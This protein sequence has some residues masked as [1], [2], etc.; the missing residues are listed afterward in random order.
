MIFKETHYFSTSA[1]LDGTDACLTQLLLGLRDVRLVLPTILAGDQGLGKTTA[2]AVMK[3]RM[4]RSLNNVFVKYIACK[5]LIGKRVDVIMKEISDGFDDCR[6]RH[7]SVLMLDDLDKLCPS[8]QG[9]AEQA[10]AEES[11]M[12]GY[13]EDFK[14]ISN[15]ITLCTTNLQISCQP[16]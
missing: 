13:D 7:P 4:E 14:L 2:M 8:Q 6:Y 1:A 11:Y 15:S 9:D 10:P 12:A 16:S 5:K 3:S